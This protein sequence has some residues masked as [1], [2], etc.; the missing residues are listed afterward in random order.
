MVK[1]GKETSLYDQLGHLSTIASNIKER[2]GVDIEFVVNERFLC[3]LS[4]LRAFAKTTTADIKCPVTRLLQI[5][6]HLN[7]HIAKTA[8]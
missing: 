1:R 8:G 3:C 6:E 4:E 5:E 2:H 7:R